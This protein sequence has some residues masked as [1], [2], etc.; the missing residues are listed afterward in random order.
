MPEL[1]EVETMV[2]DLQ[3][4]VTGRTITEV[5]ASFTGT[6]RYPA[7][8]EFAERVRGRTITSIGRRGKYAIFALDS[9]DALIVHRGMTGSLLHRTGDEPRE[10]Y[11]RLTFHLDDGTELR[12]DDPRK[13]GKVFVMNAEGRERALPWETM[14]PEPLSPDF[15]EGYLSERLAN[16]KAPIKPLLL[17]QQTVAGLGNIYVDESLY[18]AGIHPLRPAGSLTAGEIARLYESIRG[19]LSRAIHGRGTTFSSYRDIEGREG[20]YQNTLAVFR[21]SGEPCPACGTPIERIVVAGRG[22]HFCPSCQV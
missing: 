19:V 13:F 17:D 14:G 18:R 3:S 7:F 2:R 12:F 8:P 10:P 11:V 21:K 9:G 20:T 22:T 5:D 4:R 16:R 1:P 6:V 15:T